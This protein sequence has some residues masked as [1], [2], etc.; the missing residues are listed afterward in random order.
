MG[1]LDQ[2]GDFIKTPE[3]IGL[4][5]GLA[6]Y[7]ANAQRGTPINNLG[8]GA[9]TG[10]MGYNN[11]IN[12][13]EQLAEGSQ[14]RDYRKSQMEQL[15]ATALDKK[16][17]ALMMQN[18]RDSLPEADRG[19]FDMAPDKYIESMPRFQKQQLVEVAD[20][21]E[22][23]RTQKQ[24]MRPGETSGVV[25]GSGAM[26]EILDPR[27]Q[28]A[29][30]AIAAA[31]ASRT[32]VNM[33]PI[34]SEEQKALGKDLAEQYSTTQKTAMSSS[35]LLNKLNRAEQLMQGIN[36]GKLA[37]A[38]NEVAAV[39]ESFGIKL[40]PK[41]PQKQAFSALSNELALRAKNAGGENLMPGAMSEA[42][43]TFLQQMSPSM[44]NTHEGNRLIIETNKRLAKRDVEIAKMAREYRNK[45]R[46]LNGFA[47]E[48]A[49]FS[50]K[51]PL[52]KDIQPAAASSSIRS[53]ADAIIGGR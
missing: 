21:N 17:R 31:G 8:R 12:Q 43:R 22:P 34:E 36:T 48:L 45:N 24:W 37:P 25:A 13:Q 32:N 11:A 20:P 44:S 4:L 23:L 18:Y 29:K 15:Q 53:Q 49:N 28:A 6:G 46:T 51:N 47:E 41:L 40:D 19:I 1:L 33:P 5:S 2:F 27:V 7:A 10:V 16:R 35:G 39:A 14:M 26:P 52:F 50:D 3:G 42:D 9:M 38:A 30:R